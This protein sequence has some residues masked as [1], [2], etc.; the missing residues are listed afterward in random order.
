MATRA[1]KNTN[2]FNVGD[3]VRHGYDGRVLTVLWTS[4]GAIERQDQL[5]ATE[6]NGYCNGCDWAS[7]YEL[8]EAVK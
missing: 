1:R 8:D 4:K 7:I 5:I 6:Y 2:P 3:R